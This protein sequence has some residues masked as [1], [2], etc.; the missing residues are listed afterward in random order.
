MSNPPASLEEAWIEYLEV[1][2]RMFGPPPGQ[3]AGMT[4]RIFYSG[5]LAA[6]LLMSEGNS[7]ALMRDLN[8]MHVEIEEGR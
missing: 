8:K 2:T 6:V 5:A 4:R 3:S 7:D 1:L